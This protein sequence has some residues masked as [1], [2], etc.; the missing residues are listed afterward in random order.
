VKEYLV[1]TDLSPI[2]KRLLNELQIEL[3]TKV[4]G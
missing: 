3:P 4:I 2:Q 1:R